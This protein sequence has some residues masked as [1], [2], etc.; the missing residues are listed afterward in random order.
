MMALIPK[1][2][3]R[4]GKDP[5]YLCYNVPG[6]IGHP[7]VAREESDQSSK[8]KNIIVDSYQYKIDNFRG[9]LQEYFQKQ[10]EGGIKPSWETIEKRENDLKAPKI[11]ISTCTAGSITA[12]GEAGT[13]KQAI[14][15]AALAVIQEMKLIPAHEFRPTKVSA[16][17]R[18]RP[19]SLPPC[20]KKKEKK[21]IIENQQ[22]LSGNFRGALQEYLMKH[23][24]GVQ[25]EF[26]TKLEESAKSRLYIA[27]CKVIGSTDEQLKGT[28]G[29]GYSVTKKSAIHFAALDFMQKLNLLTAAEHCKIRD[30]NDE[31]NN[32][33]S[34]ATEVKA[35]E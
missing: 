14:Q 18:R 2:S 10:K 3:N 13:K 7:T 25:L 29:A 34:L 12:K 26:E 24:P 8:R 31:A 9:A 30:G 32:V 33:V 28:V 19:Q 1:S 35:M 23:H 5:V 22:Y 4:M 20:K 6:G 17:E 15:L 21:P 27:N 16:Q 11:F